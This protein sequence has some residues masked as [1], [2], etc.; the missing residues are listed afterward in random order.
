[1]MPYPSRKATAF[2]AGWPLA[3][4]VS[5]ALGRRE[6]MD[7]EVLLLRLAQAEQNVA[8]S[9]AFVARQQRLIV[10]SE[11]DGQDAAETIRLLD[12]FLLLQQL[13]EQERAKILDEMSEPS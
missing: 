6:R 8:E 1:R 5:P 7:R 10:E 13:R 4:A 12:K 3:A 2:Y 11:R 9:K